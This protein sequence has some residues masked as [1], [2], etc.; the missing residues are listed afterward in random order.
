MRLYVFSYD[1][2]SL[3]LLPL[4]DTGSSPLPTEFGALGLLD[5]D[6]VLSFS[7]YLSFFSNIHYKYLFPCWGI[8]PWSLLM[9]R[10][11][12]Q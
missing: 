9:N 8:F 12:M 3:V 4:S 1:F 2:G 10:V 5:M 7:T 6:L 11:V